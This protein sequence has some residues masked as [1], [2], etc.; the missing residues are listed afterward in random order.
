[1]CPVTTK[2]LWWNWKSKRLVLRFLLGS[3]SSIVP[4][5]FVCFG[6]VWF[7]SM[8]KLLFLFLS[9][10]SGLWKPSIHIQQG[11]FLFLYVWETK[12]QSKKESFKI[13]HNG[14]ENVRTR[15]DHHFCIFQQKSV[16][17]CWL[18]SRGLFS[19]LDSLRSI[20]MSRSAIGTYV[21]D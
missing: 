7:F 21:F 14:S 20:R 13:H 19:L 11:V 8:S 10:T 15:S 18:T 12:R 9:V 1:M 5:L 3:G 4:L 6:F 16:V 2:M 17:G